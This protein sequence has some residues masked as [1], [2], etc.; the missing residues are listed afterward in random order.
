M[1]GQAGNNGGDSGGAV[2]GVRR[3]AARERRDAAGGQRDLTDDIQRWLVRS[4]VRSMRREVT[5][6][7]RRAFHAGRPAEPADVWDAATTETPPELLA[8]SGEAPE[9]AWC[10]VCRAA[11]RIRESGQGVSGLGAPLAGAGDAVAAAVQEAFS[12]FE[13]LLGTRPRGG[14]GFP[15]DRYPAGQFPADR[16]RTAGKPARDTAAKPAPD[17]GGT[18]PRD[19]DHEPDDRG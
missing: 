3:D 12:A 14:G 7:V 2:D 5:D 8:G 4:G 1:T 19:A 13:S 17:T 9:C 11:R 18:P 15:Q 16:F 10:P 6:Q